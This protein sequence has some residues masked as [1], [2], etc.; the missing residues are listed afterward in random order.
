MWLSLVANVLFIF[1]DDPLKIME[2]L[3]YRPVSHKAGPERHC[4]SGA[5]LRSFHS[6]RATESL[7]PLPNRSMKRAFR[8]LFEVRHSLGVAVSSPHRRNGELCRSSRGTRARERPDG[9]PPPNRPRRRALAQSKAMKNSVVRITS[10]IS[11]LTALTT[12][13]AVVERPTPSAPPWVL[14]P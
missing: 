7:R 2:P 10:T 14:K 1:R 13:A 3:F 9:H 4:A 6:G 5:F 8:F 11:T 12:T